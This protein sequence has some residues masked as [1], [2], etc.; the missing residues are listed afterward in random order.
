[1]RQPQGGER[2]RPACRRRT[3]AGLAAARHRCRRARALGLR[4]L[5]RPA[6]GQCR[7]GGQYAG[8]D[9]LRDGAAPMASDPADAQ[10]AGIALGWGTHIPS[11]VI[12]AKAGIQGNAGYRHCR[13]NAVRRGQAPA[14]P[15]PRLAL[16][17]PPARG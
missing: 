5:P 10:D 7:S 3:Q 6:D 12:P 14:T 8:R 16:E 17:S 13:A 1:M 4:Q 2:N 11:I 15:A 9:R